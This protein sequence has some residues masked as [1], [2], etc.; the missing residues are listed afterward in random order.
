MISNDYV[1]I[2][3]EKLLGFQEKGFTKIFY[4]VFDT[5]EHRVRVIFPFSGEY[6]VEGFQ[7]EARKRNPTT[8]FVAEIE[9]L[10]NDLN[11]ENVESIFTIDEIEFKKFED[12]T[13][14]IARRIGNTESHN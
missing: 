10:L 13:E 9:D 12:I 7:N 3:K 5:G 1:E 14:K 6:A 2:A 4:A 8:M 11:K